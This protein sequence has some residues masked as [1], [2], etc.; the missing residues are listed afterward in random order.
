MSRALVLSA[1]AVNCYVNG[2]KFGRVTSFGW[3]SV[4]PH[5]ARYG[6][7]SADPFE[8]VPMYTKV[9][10]NLGLLR[11]VGDGG[12]EGAGMTVSFEDLPRGKYFSLMLVDR[13]SDQ[14]LF[15][16]ELCVARVQKWEVRSKSIVTGSVEFEG[17][18][19][20]NESSSQSFT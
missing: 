17:I 15:Q 16:A 10:G 4:T 7:D 18:S 11:T 3:E 5:K 1:A 13:G 19:W 9:Q 2:Q 8:L 14:V 6:I 20:T 12:T